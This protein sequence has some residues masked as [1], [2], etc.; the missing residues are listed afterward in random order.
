MICD[1]D[2]KVQHGCIGTAKDSNVGRN[3]VGLAASE[4]P[5]NRSWG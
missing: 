4:E 3:G 2:P 1:S 5:K